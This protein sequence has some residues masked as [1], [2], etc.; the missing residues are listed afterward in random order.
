MVSPRHTRVVA[1]T[2]TTTARSR[3][4]F[5]Q[6]GQDQPSFPNTRSSKSAH[7]HPRDTRDRRSGRTSFRASRLAS[8]AAR[9]CATS[10]RSGTTLQRHADRSPN[11]PR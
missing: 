6:H 5:P 11:N 3:I 4:E 2:P 10:A 1:G 7:G 9:R 8:S